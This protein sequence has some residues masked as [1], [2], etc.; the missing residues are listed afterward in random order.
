MTDAIAEPAIV[1]L[2]TEPTIGQVLHYV[3]EHMHQTRLEG[4]QSRPLFEYRVLMSA[5]GFL[6]WKEQ[7]RNQ[8]WPPSADGLPGP[9]V[10]TEIPDGSWRVCGPRSRYCDCNRGKTRKRAA[11]D[12]GDIIATHGI[13][14]SKR[15]QAA[16]DST[17]PL[18]DDGIRRLSAV[19]M[20]P[21]E[22]AS[23][24]ALLNRLFQSDEGYD[25]RETPEQA[26]ALAKLKALAEGA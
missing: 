20:T 21:S 8:S 9:I 26:A 13:I 17:C 1:V 22:A 2:T 25:V 4:R 11:G 3:R 24:L 14:V 5:D 19:A 15:D 12:L 18:C 10:V 23:L 6:R 7:V 16:P